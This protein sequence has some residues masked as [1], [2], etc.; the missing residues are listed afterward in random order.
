MRARAARAAAGIGAALALAGCAAPG[1]PGAPHGGVQGQTATCADVFASAMASR[2]AV[3]GSWACLSPAIQD[4]F[5]TLG[6]NGDAGVAQLASKQPVYTREKYL[7]RL[8]DGAYVYSLSGQSGASVLLVWL[9]PAGKV[10][11]V[12]SGGR[13]AG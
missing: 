5:R 6:L 2:A 9:D 4:Q 11:D 3:R 10:V 1:L 12:R 8:D 7:G 13:S